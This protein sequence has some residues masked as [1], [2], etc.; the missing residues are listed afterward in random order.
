[1]KTHAFNPMKYLNRLVL[2]FTVLAVTPMGVSA[3]GFAPVTGLWGGAVS[4]IAID[5]NATSPTVAVGIHGLGLFTGSASVAK[6]G[7]KVNWTIALCDAC[8]W[9][10]HASWD[11]KGRLWVAASGYGLWR[12]GVNTAF[13]EVKLAGS[14][15]VHYVARGGDGTMWAVL[16]TGVVQITAEDGVKTVGKNAGYLGL[17]KLALPTN[18]GGEVYAASAG[19]VYALEANGGWAARRVPASPTVIAQM[20]GDLYAGTTKGVFRLSGGNWSALGPIN[21][22]VTGLTLTASGV[23]TVSTHSAGVQTLSAGKWVNDGTDTFAE[24][25]ALTLASDANG[26]V[27]AGLKSG[28]SVMQ[29]ADSLITTG[30]TGVSNSSSRAAAS[31]GLPSN[32]VRDV[33]SVGNDTY[34]LVNGQGIFSR[35]GKSNRWVAVNETLDDEPVQLAANNGSVY[36]MT[37]SGSICRLVVASNSITGWVRLGTMSLTPRTFAV[38]IGDSLWIGGSGGVVMM[39][40]TSG[41]RWAAA[42]KGLERAGD[43]SRLLAASSGVFYAGTTRGGVFRWDA[44]TKSWLSVGAGGL[45]V[46]NVPGGQ[47]TSPVNSM[48]DDGD[49]LYVGTNHGVHWLSTTAKNAAWGAVGAGLPE[50][51]TRS[52]AVDSKGNLIA[53]TINGAWIVSP[54]GAGNKAAWIEY[55]DSKGEGVNAVIKV[56]N[57][58]I[59]AT[60][61]R[62]GKPGKVLV[63]N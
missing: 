44:A 9:G 19:E 29:G 28:L 43:V 38:G 51:M 34:A 24:K 57:E 59:V 23:L 56:G 52:L 5:R 39:R 36:T 25:R 41:S 4:M 7:S 63:G 33:V 26:L 6:D 8:A 32:D 27:Y 55:A 21:A 37:V 30:R 45:P 3:Q 35:V 53:G 22:H 46:V 31:E 17:D 14:N 16:G 11:D 49:A 47:A 10:R 58:V 18:T 50:V 20:N 1:M 15:I 2:A 54:T 12:G 62:P 13:A 60:A 40:E 48:I 42:M 61:T